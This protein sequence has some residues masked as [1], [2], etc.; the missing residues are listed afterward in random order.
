M[1]TNFLK[2]VANTIY[3]HVISEQLAAGDN[4]DITPDFGISNDWWIDARI[5]VN[6]RETF[7]KGDYL[8]P[9]YCDVEYTGICLHPYSSIVDSEGEAREFDRDEIKMINNELKRLCA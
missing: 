5:D 7:D 6:T 1:H 3:T 2:E 4:Q 8:T 9:D